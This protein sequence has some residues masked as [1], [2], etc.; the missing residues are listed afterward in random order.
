MDNE[1]TIDPPPKHA[2]HSFHWAY[3]EK[4]RSWLV[5]EVRDGVLWHSLGQSWNSP[6]L[7]D[8]GWRYVGPAI[9]PKRG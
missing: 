5:F 9:P 4:D 6:T 7:Y 1:G 3:R 8:H 2:H